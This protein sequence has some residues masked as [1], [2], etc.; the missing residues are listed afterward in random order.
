MSKI[1]QCAELIREIMMYSSIPER[2]KAESKLDSVIEAMLIF[3]DEEDLI[4]ILNKALETLWK[5]RQPIF[6]EYVENKI[7][8]LTEC[9]ETINEE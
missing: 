1:K 8:Y 3:L 9:M 4:E 6:K 2:S 7:S 5:P